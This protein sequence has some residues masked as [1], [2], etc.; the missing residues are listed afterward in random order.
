[1]TDGDTVDVLKI[2]GLTLDLGGAR[3]LG[4]VDLALQ[5]GRILGSRGRVVRARP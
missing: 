4:G 3:I 5:P 1:M 2:S